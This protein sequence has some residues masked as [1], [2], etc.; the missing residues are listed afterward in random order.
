VVSKTAMA[1]HNRRFKGIDGFQEYISKDRI[2]KKLIDIG[3]VSLLD[4]GF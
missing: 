2:R 4:F 1:F 3:L